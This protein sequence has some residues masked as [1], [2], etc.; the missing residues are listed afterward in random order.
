MAHKGPANP[1]RSSGISVGAVLC[2]I[3][4]F[5]LWRRRIG[6][7]EVVGAVGVVLLVLGF[8]QPRL[9][10]PLSVVWWKFSAY[11]GWFNARVLLSIFFLLILTPLGLAW[12][13]TGKDSLARRRKNWTGWAPYPAR[14]K[15]KHHFTKMY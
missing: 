13:L 5:L 3:A 12:R 7:A 6:S 4:I 15:D 10:K 11:L 8:L 14:Y 9:L 1:E 2:A